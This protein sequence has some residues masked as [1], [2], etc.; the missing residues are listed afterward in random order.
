MLT[1]P[2]ST[3]ECEHKASERF[4]YGS[5]L[6]KV[7]RDFLFAVLVLHF[8]NASFHYSARSWPNEGPADELYRTDSTCVEP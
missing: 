7:Q 2:E 6:A 8:Q 4:K 5:T 1:L 3:V